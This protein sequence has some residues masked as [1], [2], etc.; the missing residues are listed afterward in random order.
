MHLYSHTHTHTHT[1]QK[2]RNSAEAM[3]LFPGQVQEIQRLDE[4]IKGGTT[5]VMAVVI[6]NKLY[7]ANCG[8]SRAVLCSEVSVVG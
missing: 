5:A 4:Q 6:N 7:V 8:D 2:A 1:Q 3:S